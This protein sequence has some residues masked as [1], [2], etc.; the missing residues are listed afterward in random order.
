MWKLNGI[1]ISLSIDMYNV[2]SLTKQKFSI[3]LRNSAALFK[4]NEMNLK[5]EK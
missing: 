5:L 2:F 3:N 1:K 4:L